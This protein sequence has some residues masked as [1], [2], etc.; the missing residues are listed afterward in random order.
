MEPPT[1]EEE[2]SQLFEASK[3]GCSA[4]EKANQE[5]EPP[6]NPFLVDR[7]PATISKEPL[8][9]VVWQTAFELRIASQP[10]AFC[11]VPLLERR[12]T[13]GGRRLLM[14]PQHSCAQEARR[15]SI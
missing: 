12:R 9:T 1:V 6:R 2:F 8:L 14:D 11:Q 4:F 5:K 3:L 15:S 13:Q 10:Q 7:K